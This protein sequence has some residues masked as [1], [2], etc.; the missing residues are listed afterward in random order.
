MMQTADEA[1]ISALLEVRARA[2]RAKDAEA[3]LSP[4]APDFLCYDLAPPL[5]RAGAAA[6]DRGGLT[7]WFDTWRGPIRYDLR[8]LA[9]TVS[10]DIAFGH[11]LLRIGG[12]KKDGYEADLWTRQTVCLRRRNGAWQLVHEHVSTPFYMDGSLRAAVD[13]QPEEE[14]SS[15]SAGR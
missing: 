6:L 15:A 9:I 8:D 3:A 13:L 5:A 7:A 14:D 12:T 1:A 4:C 11:G 10:G 2:I